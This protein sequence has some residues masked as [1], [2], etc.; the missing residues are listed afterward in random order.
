MQ[1]RNEIPQVPAGKVRLAEWGSVPR[2]LMVEATLIAQAPGIMHR[3]PMV[4]LMHK[5]RGYAPAGSV[6]RWDEARWAVLWEPGDGTQHGRNFPE[7]DEGEAEARALFAKWTDPQEVSQRRQQEAEADDFYREV[8]AQRAAEEAQRR[9]AEKARKA[10][11][12]KA[13]R[14]ARKQLIA[15]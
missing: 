2:D 1:N 11:L 14:Q 7:T 8:R 10:A 15:A 6:M 4:R 5:T 12:A 9:E 13:R 3:G